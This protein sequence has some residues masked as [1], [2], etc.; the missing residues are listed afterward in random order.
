MKPA[1]LEV[2]ETP[3]LLPRALDSYERE[4]GI[5]TDDQGIRRRLGGT[6][7]P[8]FGNLA[9]D[10][11]AWPPAPGTFATTRSAHPTSRRKSNMP[12]E[13]GLL[14]SNAAASRRQ[15]TRIP[16]LRR[17]VVTRRRPVVG[18][19][20]RRSGAIR[21]MTRAGCRA[22]RAPQ[23][24]INTPELISGRRIWADTTT[25]TLRSMPSDAGWSQQHEVPGHSQIQPQREP[26]SEISSAR[27]HKPR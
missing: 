7:H 1:P 25:T 10:V 6:A 9:L 16:G 3:S 13:G 21:G 15:C 2:Q 24:A 12:T 11:A 8:L 18:L 19:G 22:P 20:S 17:V 23:R 14:I 5:S 4:L 27:L 26:L